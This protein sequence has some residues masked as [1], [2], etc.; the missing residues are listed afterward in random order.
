MRASQHHLH[1]PLTVPHI[2]RMGLLVRRATHVEHH[3]HG[4]SAT[5]AGSL[6]GV[7]RLT[8]FVLLDLRQNV[9]QQRLML[10]VDVAIALDRLGQARDQSADSAS[11]EEISSTLCRGRAPAGNEED[12]PYLRKV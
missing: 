12:R 5:A 9:L 8:Q 2:H 10:C 4:R 11:T 1:L 6:E 7:V 3:N